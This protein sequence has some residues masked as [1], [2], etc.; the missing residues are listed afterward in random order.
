MIKEATNLLQNVGKVNRFVQ[1]LFHFPIFCLQCIKLFPDLQIFS[2]I[3]RQLRNCN[4]RWK[5]SV[6]PPEVRGHWFSSNLT[7]LFSSNAISNFLRRFSASSSQCLSERW[8]SWRKLNSG[9]YHRCDSSARNL[10]V[11]SAEKI[12]MSK[13]QSKN[14]DVSHVTR[15]R[16][17]NIRIK[18]SQFRNTWRHVRVGPQVERQYCTVT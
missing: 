1:G 6:A 12:Q 16:P 7:S 11:W 8:T 4:I 15:G 13:N 9:Y 17:C 14:H 18:S 2:T 10:A 5:Y 3:N